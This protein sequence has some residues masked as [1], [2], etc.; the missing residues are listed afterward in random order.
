MKKILL[1]L[2][3]L[4]AF[5][6]MNA[7]INS[8]VLDQKEFKVY[9]AKGI[10]ATYKQTKDMSRLITLSYQNMEYQSIVDLGFIVFSEQHKLDK[11]IKHLEDGL[12]DLEGKKG[13]IIYTGDNYK[14]LTHKKGRWLT[15]Y[16]NEDKSIY[17]IKKQIVNFINWL[18]N[19][20][21]YFAGE[22]VKE[23][24]GCRFTKS[25]IDEFTGA[26]KKRLS[27]EVIGKGGGYE[28]TSCISR[29]NES[30]FI[31]LNFS[32]DLGCISSKS[33]VTIKFKD[34]SVLTLKNIGDIDCGKNPTF[35][36]N[37]VDELEIISS[38]EISKLRL[39]MND[40]YSDI[41]I[42]NSSYIIDALKCLSE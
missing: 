7:Q 32:G 18:K 11:F 2:A 21:I 1:T 4:L 34:D 37:I 31:Y 6:A 13:G 17:I 38:K 3:V 28:L 40:A 36:A 14:L 16:D 20:E 42:T 8:E 19:K 30:Y 23:V 26:V 29:V 27:K 25:E 35:I 10:T 33:Y 22:K 15:V 5:N 39:S 41:D 24:N 9:S 12:S